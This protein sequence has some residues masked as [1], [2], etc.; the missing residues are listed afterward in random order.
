MAADKGLRVTV[1]DE[2]ALRKGRFGGM[3]A[4]GSGSRHG[5]RLIV[6]EHRGGPSSQAPIALVGKAIT[7]D[8]GGISIKPAANMEEMI[9]DKCGGMAVLGAMR[10][11]ADLRLKRNVV[12]IVASAENLP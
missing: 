5:P 6:L 10:G 11:M 8:S 4:V 12:G 7:F 3:L 2:K 9:F 1:L